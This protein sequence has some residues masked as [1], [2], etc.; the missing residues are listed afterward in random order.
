MF[1]V[2]AYSLYVSLKNGAGEDIRGEVA[3][4]ALGTTEGHGDIKAK[5][6]PNDYPTF[7]GRVDQAASEQSF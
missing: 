6:H 3:I 1:H 7:E 4:A 5:R 2:S